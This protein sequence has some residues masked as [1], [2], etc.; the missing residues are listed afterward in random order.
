M[1]NPKKKDPADKTLA[2]HNTYATSCF[3]TRAIPLLRSFFRAL[4][5]LSKSLAD[6]K[7]FFVGLAPTTLLLHTPRSK[8]LTPESTAPAPA[9]RSTPRRDLVGQGP[10]RALTCCTV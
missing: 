4:Q 2:G 3:G 9:Q 8:V 10:A 5:S 6:G 7:V 1:Q